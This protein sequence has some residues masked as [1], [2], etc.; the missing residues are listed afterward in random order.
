[1]FQPQLSPNPANG[2]QLIPEIFPKEPDPPDVDKKSCDIATNLA[3]LVGIFDGSVK[4]YFYQL[5][6]VTDGS[7][8]G[9]YKAVK[10]QFT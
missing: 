8:E 4:D 9:L 5:L 1:M 3:L 7:A 10:Q 6:T 2:K